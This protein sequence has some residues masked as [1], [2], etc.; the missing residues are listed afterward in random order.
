MIKEYPQH[1]KG[2]QHY[3]E[4]R[5]HFFGRNYYME[6]DMGRKYKCGVIILI[7]SML[8]MLSACGGETETPLVIPVDTDGDGL[9]DIQETG[10]YGTSPV[11]AD[12]DGDGYSDGDEVLQLGVGNSNPYVY[13]PLVADLPQL[14]VEITSIPNIGYDFS[15]SNGKTYQDSTTRSQ[16]QSTS[17]STS[18]GGSV[19]VG[20]EAKAE[21]SASLT[22]PEA[23]ASL[24]TSMESTVSFDTTTM[25][26]NQNTYSQMVT[27][28]VEKSTTWNGGNINVTVKLSNPGHIAYTL[29]DL[30]LSSTK[31]ADGQEPFQALATLKYKGGFPP[32]SLSGGQS[33][34]DLPFENTDLTLQNV[35]TMLTAARSMSIKPATFETTDITDTPFAFK[36][37]EVDAKTAKILI[38]YG[39]YGES[40]LYQV[41][42][43]SDPNNPGRKLSDILGSILSVA[44]TES[45]G[46][47]TIRSKP[48][49]A[50]TGTQRW[51]VTKRYNQ[52]QGGIDEVYD[53]VSGA[54]SAADIHVNVGD[55]ILIVYLEDADGDGLGYRE[56][57]VNGTDPNTADTDGDGLDDYEEVRDGWVVAAINQ[58]DANRYPAKVF[59]SPISADYDGDLVMDAAEKARGLDPYNEDTDGDG[60]H[61]NTDNSTAG[62]P[63]SNNLTV[64][65]VDLSTVRVS[66]SVSA[67][68]PQTLANVELDWGDSSTP[69]TWNG[70]ISRAL[71][72]SDHVYA[73]PGTYTITLTMSDDS[74]PTANTLV[75]TAK[76][77]LTKSSRVSTGGGWDSAWRVTQHVRTVADLNQDGFDDVIR[78]GNARTDV[79]LGSASGLQ[80]ETTWSTANW[81]TNQYA[82]VDTDPRF[83]VDIDNDGDLDIVGVD[84]SANIVRYGLNNGS[85]FDAPVD[86]ITGINWNVGYDSAYLV[87][88]D[89]NNYPDF[90]HAKRNGRLTVYTSNGASLAHSAAIVDAQAWGSGYPDRRKYPI[91]ASDLDGDGCTDLVL[92]GID[93]TFSN[94][95]NCDGT[96]VGW[97][98]LLDSELDYNSKWRTELHHRELVDLNNDGRPDFIGFGT[99]GVSVYLNTST[100]GSISIE[101]YTIW[102]SQFVSNQGWAMEKFVSPRYW[103]NISPRYLSDV[104]GDGFTDVVGYANAGVYVLSNKLGIDRTA[105]FAPYWFAAPDFNISS[106]TG[107]EWWEDHTDP[108]LAPISICSFFIPCREYF[109]R[110]VGDF[111]GDDRADFL[112]FDQTGIIYQPA[113]YVTQFK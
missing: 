98:L 78:I 17:T 65:R 16:S 62:A 7:L 43:N 109:P 56:E 28:G 107:G 104:D 40:E 58:H 59:S 112:G 12:T 11:M 20:V 37:E 111:N 27:E 92:F 22:G 1:R 6:I 29:K 32:Q 102:S 105:G 73:S 25:T 95:S 89:N 90:V 49:T 54:Y 4:P 15:D 9:T 69:E 55:E 87:D 96:F 48:A 42:T 113:T 23:S 64:T 44:Y 75:Q 51:V 24:T 57:I 13:N 45:S 18:F 53:S 81:T 68:S 83:F 91:M 77:V 88:V 100:P 85:G 31:A 79:M 38:D 34:I 80:A 94:R 108:S 30:S 21:V 26:E 19:T 82:H 99:A 10:T 76:V 47:T 50:P 41:A 70:G 61:D 106:A 110:M 46:I 72:P 2:Q 71:K 74:T 8:L 60:D 67:K 39:P 63:L 35:R 14:K 84:A 101:P 97:T 86:W 3:I 36:Q 66:G 5:I 93:D 103:Y 33:R 52:G